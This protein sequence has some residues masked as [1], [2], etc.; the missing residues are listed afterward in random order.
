[1]VAALGLSIF[2]VNAFT[3]LGFLN[4]GTGLRRPASYWIT[5]TAAG[6]FVF[7]AFLAVQGLAAHLLSYRLFLRVSGF[8]QIG[9][10]FAVLSLYFLTP[11]LP[12]RTGSRRPKTNTCWRGCLRSGFSGCSSSFAATLTL[13]SRLS[14]PAPFAIFLWS[15]PPQPTPTP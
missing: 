2:A 6:L 11:P 14:P 1:M 4:F 7:S 15:S 8:L 9:A 5:M 3:G 13:C 12:L 10:L